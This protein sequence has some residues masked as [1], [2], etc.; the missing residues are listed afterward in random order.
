MSI[1]RVEDG[2]PVFDKGLQNI[3]EN[4]FHALDGHGVV[5]GDIM[6]LVGEVEWKTSLETNQPKPKYKDSENLPI[7]T[8]TL[9]AR[10]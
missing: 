4:H 2:L 5:V 6:R 7:E 1:A 8:P 9:A 10:L 3:S